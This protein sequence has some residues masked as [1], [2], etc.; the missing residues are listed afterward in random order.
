MVCILR[1]GACPRGASVRRSIRLVVALSVCAAAFPFDAVRAQA[2]VLIDPPTVSGW[3]ASDIQI[4][5]ARCTQLLK[6]LHLVFKPLPAVRQNDCG[7]AAPIEVSSVG[8]S[9]QIALSPPV[10]VTCD[11]AVALHRWLTAD[12]QG[13]AR[14]HLGSD[15]VRVDTMSSYSCRTAYGRKNARLSEHGKANA[16]DIRAFGTAAGG[17]SDVLADW[18]PTGLEIAAQVATA[19]KVEAERSVASAPAPSKA[20]VAGRSHPATT[21]STSAPPI[22]SAGP[23]MQQDKSGT[24]VLYGIATG[25]I[26]AQQPADPTASRPAISVGTRGGGP[27]VGLPMPGASDTGLGLWPGMGTPARLGGPKVNGAMPG[28]ANKMDFL[29]AAHASACRVFGTVLGPEANSAHRN[30]FH[31]DMAERKVRSICE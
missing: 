24:P 13:L 29:R 7:A 12:L 30:H 17:G 4:E 8:K 1:D 5:Q 22:A 2:P 26:P 14:K 28:Q 25:S 18:G 3:S 31:V 19:K 16:V 20:T 21:T 23:S 9:P 11:M 15:L 10:V 6:G 27:P